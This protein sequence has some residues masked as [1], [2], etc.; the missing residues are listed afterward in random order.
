MDQGRVL[1]C[2]YVGAHFL[3]DH[4][5]QVSHLGTMLQYVLAV[6]GA[7][8]QFAHQMQYFFRYADYPDFPGSI[9]GGM[10]DILINFFLRF[11]NN[12][13]DPSGVYPSV[14]NQHLQRLPGNFSAH[15]IKT[16]EYDITGC[17]VNHNVDAGGP[18]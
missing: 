4:T 18:L 8:F 2:F 13:F 14:L 17:V 16:A 7:V 9:F 15:R 3:G 11:F 1:G 12:F 5:G 6:T 10:D